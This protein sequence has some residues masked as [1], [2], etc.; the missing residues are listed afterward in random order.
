MFVQLWRCTVGDG[1]TVISHI[2]GGVLFFKLGL[3][4][5]QQQGCVGDCVAPEKEI[6]SIRARQSS[7]L[8]VI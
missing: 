8:E 6:I 1:P 3:E 2:Q 4:E 7:L 5:K